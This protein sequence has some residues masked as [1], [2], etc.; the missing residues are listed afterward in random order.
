VVNA[1]RRDAFQRIAHLICEMY[2][3]MKAIGLVEDGEFTLPL[4][5]EYRG[6][7]LTV[8]DVDGLERVAG[9]DSVLSSRRA[10]RRGRRTGMRPTDF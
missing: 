10:K 9:F 3:R 7:Q 1:G 2:F 6:G 8:L 4:T 5:Q